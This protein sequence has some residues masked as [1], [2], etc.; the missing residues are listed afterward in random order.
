MLEACDPASCT[1][2]T[3][4]DTR[5]QD[6]TQSLLGRMLDH[7]FGLLSLD[8]FRQHLDYSF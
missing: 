2:H 1:G 5:D 4:S 6:E 8:H 7:S 3:V